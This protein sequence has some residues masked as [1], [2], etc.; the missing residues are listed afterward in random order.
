MYAPVVLRFKSYLIKVGTVEE[1]YMQ[2]M[3]SLT[4]LQEWI[5]DALAEEEIIELYEQ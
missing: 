5:A 2:S 1:E 3:L 4:S